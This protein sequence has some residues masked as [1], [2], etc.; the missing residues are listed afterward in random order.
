[1]ENQAIGFT[2]IVERENL[3][4]TEQVKQEYENCVFSA[5]EVEGHPID[6]M[7]MKIEK[8]GENDI[9]LLLRPDEMAAIAWCASGTLWSELIGRL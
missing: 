4:F 7:Y 1:M 8:S 6:T 9:L 3:I 5:G 2:R